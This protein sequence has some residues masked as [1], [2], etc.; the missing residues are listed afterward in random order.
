MEARADEMREAILLHQEK[1]RRLEEKLKSVTPVTPATQP[2]QLTPGP[3]PSVPEV[4]EVPA[5]APLEFIINDLTAG[6]N[7]TFIDTVLDSL[8]VGEYTL[9]KHRIVETLFN[10]KLTDMGKAESKHRLSSILMSLI[11][12]AKMKNITFKDGI[13]Q[14]FENYMNRINELY[15]LDLFAKGIVDDL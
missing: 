10:D 9:E 5:E 3:G 15:D 6:T 11:V 13:K 7:T 8:P 1:V 4:P 12:G 2:T 14:I